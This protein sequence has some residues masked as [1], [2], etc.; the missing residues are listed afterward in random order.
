MNWIEEEVSFWARWQGKRSDLQQNEA[1]KISSLS[2]VVLSLPC[3]PSKRQQ[4]AVPPRAFC[5]S[6]GEEGQGEWKKETPGGEVAHQV[7]ESPHGVLVGTDALARVKASLCHVSAAK[8]EGR[9]REHVRDTPKRHR[10]KRPWHV[11][12][13]ERANRCSRAVRTSP[14][15]PVTRLSPTGLCRY[16]WITAKDSVQCMVVQRTS[17]HCQFLL[18]MH[19]QLCISVCL[20]HK[21]VGWKWQASTPIQP[22]QTRLT[23]NWS[24]HLSSSNTFILPY[25]HS[26]GRPISN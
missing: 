8:P 4:R 15:K 26:R 11:P 23:R 1:K 21:T 6:P 2:L 22:I 20:E 16:L 13:E 10:G 5:Y 3:H 9:T 17:R 12:S 18:H 7:D 14:H 19:S 25:K 24:F